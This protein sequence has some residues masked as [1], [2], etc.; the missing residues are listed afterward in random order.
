MALITCIEC[1]KEFSDKASA[2]PNCACPTEVVL[3]EI[4]EIGGNASGATNVNAQPVTETT[5]SILLIDYGY[6]KIPV[7]NAVRDLK[8]IGQLQAVRIVERAPVIILENVKLEEAEVIRSNFME[9]GA[10]IQFTDIKVSQVPEKSESTG[11]EVSKQATSSISPI[12]II[13]Y[14]KERSSSTNSSYGTVRYVDDT[15]PT[16]VHTDNKIYRDPTRGSSRS[17]IIQDPSIVCPR[18]GSKNYKVIS[19]VSKG[20]AWG[21]FGPLAAG[22]LLSKYQCQNCKHNF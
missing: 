8:G 14:V 7:I 2:C 19:G 12:P 5:V 11:A 6:S 18:C 15:N 9:I 13:D 20:V 22:K 17:R 4:K 3:K 21:L 16:K 10:V 1:G